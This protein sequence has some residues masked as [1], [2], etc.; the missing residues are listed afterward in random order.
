[1]LAS[2]PY[3]IAGIVFAGPHAFTCEK[4]GIFAQNISA[5]LQKIAIRGTRSAGPHICN[6]HVQRRGFGCTEARFGREYGAA[7]CQVV[8]FVGDETGYGLQW[9]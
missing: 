2:T 4:I 6:M 1:V 9:E 5:G 7:L 8:C 3:A